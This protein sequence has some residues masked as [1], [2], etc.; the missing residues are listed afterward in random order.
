M[1]RKQIL[2]Y[3]LYLGKFE[4]NTEKNHNYSPQIIFLN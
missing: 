2:K 4:E 1:V 3:D